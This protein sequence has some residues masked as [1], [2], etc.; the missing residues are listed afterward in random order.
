MKTSSL[1][2]FGQKSPQK[3][4]LDPHLTPGRKPVLECVTMHPQQVDTVFLAEGVPGLGE[5][6]HACKENRVRYRKIPRQE[7]D[8]M[9]PGAHQGVIAR[10]RGR[11]FMDLP[12]FLD[13]AARTPLPL[14]LALDQIQDPGNAGTLARSLL[15]L[16]GG[17]LL[18]PQDRSAFL[19]QAAAKAAAGALDR[20]PLCQVTNLARALD[21]CHDAGFAI[22]GSGL[23]EQTTPLFSETF[24]FP[25]VLV[26]GNE[27]K[28]IRPN[29]AKRCQAMLSIP[30]RGG[31]DSLNVAQAGAMIMGEMLRQRE[32]TTPEK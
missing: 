27:D 1:P 7:L 18:F 17:G 29:V 11:E 22:Y 25:A 8:R 4:H 5:I 21:A 31:W 19:G 30:M 32:Y 24:I 12:V 16:G 15:A 13:Q 20:L 3:T 6:T 2:S 23:T 10:L 14:I 28:G 26:L 9:Y